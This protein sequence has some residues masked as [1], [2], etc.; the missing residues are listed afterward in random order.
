[1]PIKLDAKKIARLFKIGS[2]IEVNL[3]NQI[4]TIPNETISFDIEHYRKKTLLEG[5]DD[6]SITLKYEEK[7]SQYEKSKTVF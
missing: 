1:M 7:I 4:I 5:L 2:E 3:E 6:I